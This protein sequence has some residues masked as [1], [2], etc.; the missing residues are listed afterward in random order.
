MCVFRL[1]QTRITFSAD[2]NLDDLLPDR[3]AAAHPEAV[4]TYRL[5]ESRGKAAATRDRRRRRRTLNKKRPR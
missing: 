1:S 3:W 5:E 4:L 2:A